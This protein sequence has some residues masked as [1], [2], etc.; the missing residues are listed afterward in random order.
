MS[1]RTRHAR[2]HA[3]GGAAPGRPR[4]AVRR[5]PRGVARAAPATPRSRGSCR[6][7]TPDDAEPLRRISVSHPERPARARADGCRGACSAALGEPAT[8][9]DDA[10]ARTTR[11]SWNSCELRLSPK[12]LRA[13]LRYLAAIRLVLASRLG[14]RRRGRPRRRRSSVRRSTTGSAIGSTGWCRPPI[15]ATESRGPH[16]HC[17]D[18]RRVQP[19]GSSRAMWRSSCSAHRVQCGRKVSPSR[20]S[21]RRLRD[22]GG[23]SSHTRMSPS[24]A[25]VGSE[26]P[27]ALDDERQRRVDGV[28]LGVSRTR[29]SPIAARRRS[30]RARAARGSGRA[31]PPRRRRGRPTLGRGNR[32]RPAAPARG[33]ATARP[34]LRAR[35]V[36]SGTA[37]AVDEYD[38]IRRGDADDGAARTGGRAVEGGATGSALSCLEGADDTAE[39]ATGDPHEGDR[40]REEGDDV[41]LEPEVAAA[42]D[43][44]AERHGV[45]AS[46]AA[47]VARLVGSAAEAGPRDGD[48]NRCGRR[49]RPRCSP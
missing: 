49:R 16:G 6:M 42:T 15:R 30:A 43:V 7:P 1:E 22:R 48:G 36:L 40:H 31:L 28:R 37:A 25:V 34:A 18:V 21:A 46:S 45:A 14:I 12:R 39:C 17:E 4:D 41:R 3:H 23:D 35:L 32:G 24:R 27:R 9:P 26:Q 47:A 20:S 2:D 8:L 10:E 38:R 33:A 29:P 19:A 44:C 11:S 13:W 5:A